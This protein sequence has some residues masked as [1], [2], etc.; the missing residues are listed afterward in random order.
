MRQLLVQSPARTL[1]LRPDDP[2]VGLMV[3]SRSQHLVQ[4]PTT[5]C[6]DNSNG[7]SE[8]PSIGPPVRNAELRV[9][10]AQSCRAA[11]LTL[12]L[13][14]GLL[15]SVITPTYT[16]ASTASPS[17]ACAHSG[18]GHTQI[19]ATR[20]ALTKTRA[21]LARTQAQL[22][23]HP[24]RPSA[25]LRAATKVLLRRISHLSLELSCATSADAPPHLHAAPDTVAPSA[26]PAATAAPS[27]SPAPLDTPP[28]TASSSEPPSVPPEAEPISP[29]LPTNPISSPARPPSRPVRSA[30]VPLAI[31]VSG[32]SLI[33]GNGEPV[34]LH[35]VNISSTEWQCLYGEAFES[36]DSEASIAAI[37][38]WHVN[39]VRIPLNEDCWLGI[40][41]APTDMAAYHEIMRNYVERLNAHGIYAILDL[42]WSAPGTTISHLGPRF[43]GFFEMADEDHTPDFWASIASYFESNHAVLF[44]LF[45]EPFGVSWSCWLNGCIAP[46]GFQTAGMQ[47]LVD[48]IRATGATQPIMVGGLGRAGEAGHAWLENHPID[49]A[50]QLVASVHAYDQGNINIFN[51]NIGTVA[52]QFPVVIGEMGEKDCGDSDLNALLPW[53]DAHGVSYLAWAWYT[54][55]CGA[56]PALI[57]N[58]SGSPT[59]YGLGYREHLM[60]TFPATEPG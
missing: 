18:S 19:A 27:S 22:R 54:G 21:T 32:N 6:P 3:I 25:R 39:A 17:K 49:P 20:L 52:A 37:A 8:A 15:W 24:A 23:R 41:G 12:L 38:A 60:A 53:S 33:D 2:T 9:D 11:T 36:P 43:E 58:Y 51:T 56:Y 55:E 13:V 29:T 35:G 34:T 16:W 5:D 7:V 30:T 45:N 59:A 26:Q 14:V 44:D 42:H 40:N 1:S 28:T 47:Q 50:R 57:T 4:G 48:V 31:A 46:R 10:G